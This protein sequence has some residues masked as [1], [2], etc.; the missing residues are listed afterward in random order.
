VL[1]IIHPTRPGKAG[2]ARVLYAGNAATRAKLDVTYTEKAEG[3]KAEGGKAA[4]GTQ[5]PTMV[6]RD[7]GRINVSAPQIL[8]AV[9][10]ADRVSEIELQIDATDDREAGRAVDALDNLV[11]LQAAGLYKATLSYDHV[12]RIAVNVALRDARTRRIVRNTGTSAPSN[13]RVANAVADSVGPDSVGPELKLGAYQA[14][15]QAIHQAIVKW[16]HVISPDEAE[17]IVKKLAAYPEIKAYKV[18]ESYRGR[19]ISV[20]E[21]TLPTPSEQVSVAKL[22]AYKPTIFMMGRQHANEVSSTSHILR[23]GELLATDPSYR[24]IL[25]KVNVILCPVQNPDGA[26]ISY[27]LQ[28]LTPNYMLHAGRYSALGADLSTA[29]ATLLPEAEVNGKIWRE[30][31]PDIYLNPHGYPSHEW[32]QQFAGYVPPGFRAYWDSR[33]WYTMMSGLRDPRYPEHASAVAAL[34]EAVVR[35]VNS[36]SD[37][38]AMNVR[39]QARYTRWAYGF[40][41]HVYNIEVYKDTTIF[42]SDPETGE[43][44]GSRRAAGATGASGGSGR[45]ASMGSWPQVTFASGM[46]EAP[47]E[48]AQG[49]W[50]NLVTKAGFSFLM[51]H[52]NYLRDGQYKIERVEEGGQRDAATITMLRVRPVMPAKAAGKPTT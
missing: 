22:T 20:M 24:S 8:R 12:D 6:S 47:D 36:N 34:R 27:D 10:R 38:H 1:P 48:T 19:D 26:A 13:V 5:K 51:A 11:C 49:E 35:E 14:I 41:P 21:I 18:G 32:V 45:R 16:D 7:L 25:K 37:V 43:P 3:A 30:W 28:K 15:Y 31:L 33:G 39:H 4:A 52:V 9:V 42:Y 17:Q 50:M 40:G 46:T 23:L 2:E 29:S 44:R